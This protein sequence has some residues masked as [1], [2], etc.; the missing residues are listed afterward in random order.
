MAEAFHDSRPALDLAALI[1]PVE[2]SAF[3]ETYWGQ[4]PLHVRAEN[5]TR[6][7]SLFS[8][9]DM[10]R[11]LTEYGRS[12]KLDIRISKHQ[13]GRTE[14]IDPASDVVP[15]DVDQ[16]FGAYSNGFSLNVNRIN[17]CHAPVRELAIAL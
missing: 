1:A 14:V 8:T 3:F 5:R 12:P 11:L 4:K 16:V 10:D 2:T 17:E 13:N 15:V 9:T 7:S 6:F